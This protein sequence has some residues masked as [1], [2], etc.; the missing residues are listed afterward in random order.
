MVV[1]ANMFFKY[2]YKTKNLKS[3]GEKLEFKWFATH[4]YQ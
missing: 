3:L 2:F 4:Y 1:D